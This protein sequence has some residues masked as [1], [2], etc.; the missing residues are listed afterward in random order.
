M[1]ISEVIEPFFTYS[2]LPQGLENVE[3]LE[4]YY[5]WTKFEEKTRNA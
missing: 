1:S 2:E 5:I 3:N 4:K